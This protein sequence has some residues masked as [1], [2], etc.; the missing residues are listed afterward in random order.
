MNEQAEPKRAKRR[1]NHKPR[2]HSRETTAVQRP[3]ARQILRFGHVN[4][5]SGLLSVKSAAGADK[6]KAAIDT[7][8]EFNLD[9][10]AISEASLTDDEITQLQKEVRDTSGNRYPHLVFLGTPLPKPET[11]Q[12]PSEQS[13]DGTRDPRTSATQGADLLQMLVR[14]QSDVSMG[15]RQAPHDESGRALD[16]EA[17]HF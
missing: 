15:W 9:C 13:S 5:A 14:M 6:M 10:L 2:H 11:K 7:M 1:R 4:M 12:R 8:T 16:E 3:Q 17:I